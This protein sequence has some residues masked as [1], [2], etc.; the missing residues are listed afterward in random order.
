MNP[1]EKLTGE[2]AIEVRMSDG[3]V[4]NVVVRELPIRKMDALFDAQNNLPALVA[5]YSGQSVEWTDRLT[6]SSAREIVAAGDEMNS[7]FFAWLL[8]D[9]LARLERINGGLRAIAE[10]ASSPNGSQTVAYPAA[11]P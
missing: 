9:K 10:R 7:D 3:T 8:Q 5:L 6:H 2:R 11:S 4:E 1:I